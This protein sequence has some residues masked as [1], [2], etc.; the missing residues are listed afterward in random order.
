MCLLYV[1]GPQ[2][3]CVQPQCWM[4]APA[5]ESACWGIFPHMSDWK[6]WSPHDLLSTQQGNC[7]VWNLTGGIGDEVTQLIPKTKIPAHTRYALQCR[8]SPDSTYV[9]GGGVGGP[10]ALRWLRGE[11]NLLGAGGLMGWD[12]FGGQQGVQ[13]G[14]AADDTPTCSYPLLGSLPPAQLTRRARFG[15]HPISP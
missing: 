2:T 4:A 15:G 9:G 1:P 10:G 3:P 6:L 12:L 14:V 7:Y 5:P 11:R 8:F 13:V